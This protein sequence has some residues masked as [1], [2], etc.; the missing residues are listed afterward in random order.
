MRTKVINKFKAYAREIVGKA[1]YKLRVYKANKYYDGYANLEAKQIN[2]CIK[3]DTTEFDL[4]DTLYH[5]LAHAYSANY[6][7]NLLKGATSYRYVGCIGISFSAKKALEVIAVEVEG[8]CIR[9]IL[10]NN[11]K[12]DHVYHDYFTRRE[13]K[14]TKTKY[15]KIIN[16]IYCDI[17][18]SHIEAVKNLKTTGR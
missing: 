16:T 6:N 3:R 2:I 5:E 10:G 14:E 18:K 12:L 4:Y 8:K 15:K 9:N 17:A 11:C 1:G 7:R 13:F